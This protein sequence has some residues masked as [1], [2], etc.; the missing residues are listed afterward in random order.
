M[1]IEVEDLFYEF[2]TDTWLGFDHFLTHKKWARVSQ[3]WL[4]NIAGNMSRSKEGQPM[5]GTLWEE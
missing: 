4:S 5:H 1:W 2:D 3:G